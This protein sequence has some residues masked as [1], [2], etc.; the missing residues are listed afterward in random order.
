MNNFISLLILLLIA[1]CYSYGQSVTIGTQVWTT[2]NLEVTKF[3]NGDPI[4]QA[5]TLEEMEAFSKAKEPAWCYYDFNTSSGKKYGKMYNGYAMIDPRNIAP[6]G[7]HVPSND[8]Y[9]LLINFLGGEETARLK[10][11]SKS[12]W[13]ENKNGTNSSGFSGLPGGMTSRYKFINEEF[14]TSYWSN[15]ASND[16]SMVFYSIM[17]LS[18]ND[19]KKYFTISGKEYSNYVTGPMTAAMHPINYLYIRLVKD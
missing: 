13:F 11:K 6:I 18:Y 10:L 12:G 14:N 4:P 15:T 16:G 1:N 3:R 19:E 9:L 2:K 17:S 8:E 5:K 7:W